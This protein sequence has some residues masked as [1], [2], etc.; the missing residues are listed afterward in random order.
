MLANRATNVGGTIRLSIREHE[1][2]DEGEVL[3]SSEEG[4][5]YEKKNTPSSKTNGLM[6]GW[7]SE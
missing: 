4:R 1:R 7:M 2:K 5:V 6:D 3:A